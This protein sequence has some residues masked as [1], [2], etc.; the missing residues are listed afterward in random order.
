MKGRIRR[1]IIMHLPY[2][3]GEQSNTYGKKNPQILHH[4]GNRLT[5]AYNAN[6]I[7]YKD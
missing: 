4:Q 1:L 6:V 5:C 7:M 2:F 3:S